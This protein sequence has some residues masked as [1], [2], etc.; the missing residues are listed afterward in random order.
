MLISASDV[1]SAVVNY[2][3]IANPTD[4]NKNK[5]YSAK[6]SRIFVPRI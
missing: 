5:S 6:Q 4:K 2:N 3:S 1:G